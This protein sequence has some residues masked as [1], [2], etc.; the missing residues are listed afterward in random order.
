MS[1]RVWTPILNKEYRSDIGLIM[2]FVVWAAKPKRFFGWAYQA[3]AKFGMKIESPQPAMRQLWSD[4][5]TTA[6]VALSVENGDAPVKNWA[7]VGYRDFP[8]TTRSSR[9]GD[10]AVT[11]HEKK[12]Y[13]CASCPLSCGGICG[14][15]RGPYPMAESHKPEYETLC[16]FGTLLLVG[17]RVR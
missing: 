5:G 2:R 9:I 4:R 15:E 10:D 17:K 12:K 7:G 6:A 14:Y 16:A 8:L 1:S 3:F 13:G 11:R